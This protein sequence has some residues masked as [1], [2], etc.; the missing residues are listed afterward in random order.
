MDREDGG[1]AFLQEKSPLIRMKK[2][3][4][5]IFDS[6]QIREL[7]KNPIFDEALSEAEQSTSLSLK[8]VVTN[9]QKNYRSTEYEKEI[10]ELLKS[11]HQLGARMSV[12]LHLLLWQLYHFPKN[13]RFE[14]GAG[15]VLSQRHSHCG[16]A[17]PRLVRCKLSH[18]QLLMLVMRCGSYRE[19]EKS[20]KRLFL[21]E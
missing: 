5:A 3:K 18:W 21:P 10:E 8:S 7:I 15:G 13:W 11:F 12:K 4:A 19:Q 6:H 14:R 20:L 16:K 1:F 2:P 17:L 9:F